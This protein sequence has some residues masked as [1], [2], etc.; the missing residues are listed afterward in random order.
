MAASTGSSNPSRQG[1]IF[2]AYY[3]LDRTIDN[4]FYDSYTY[5]V[6][7]YPGEFMSTVFFSHSYKPEDVDINKYFGLL[8]ERNGLVPTLD[9]PSDRVNAA[10]LERHL[11]S[12]DGMICILTQREGGVSQYIHYEMNL[13]IRSRK[14][15]LVFVED[16]VQD[17]IVPHRILQRRFS[18]R[19]FPRETRQHNHAVEVFKSY[20]SPAPEYQPAITKKSCIL[21]GF[22]DSNRALRKTVV[23]EIQRRE[24]TIIDVA[25]IRTGSL[26]DPQL[27]EAI[28]SASLAVCNMDA[29]RALAQYVIGAIQ[30]SIVPAI[31][32]TLNRD[33]PYR[34]GVPSDLQALLV[35]PRETSTTLEAIRAQ[36]DLYEQDFLSLQERE[37]VGS[38]TSILKS[39]SSKSG[40]RGDH[41]R[42]IF[43]RELV[44]GDKSHIEGDAI[45]SAIGSGATI[46]ARDI[47]VYKQKVDAAERLESDVKEKLKQARDAIEAER[48]SDADR[49]D[50]LDDLGRLTAELQAPNKSKSRIERFLNRIKEI[51]STTADIISSAVSIGKFLGL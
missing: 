50:L 14:P 36:I 49:A 46:N 12:N 48:L 17:E 8:L 24:F 42:D 1:R 11:R 47:T 9:P 16:T 31:V 40:Q 44:M 41:I 38:Y 51:S 45:G 7:G 29:P 43:V 28:A 13:C 20:L 37:L 27:A 3:I 25:K 23:Q 32:L 21:V 10:K 4:L 6:I 22:S 30:S 34:K 39:I 5:P 33:Y 35:E 18:R 15:L 2:G 19:S 26:Q